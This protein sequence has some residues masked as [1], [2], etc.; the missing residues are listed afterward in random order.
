MDL[1]QAKII[2]NKINA[3]YKNLSIDEGNIA[4]IEKELMLNYIRQLYE[5]FLDLDQPTSKKKSKKSKAPV[6]EPEF[7]VVKPKAKAPKKEYVPPKIIEIPDSLKEISEE[8]TP[9]PQPKP[10]PK[11][12]PLN[13]DAR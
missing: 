7:E 3:L 8:P 12:W 4:S 11:P 5:A 9:A 2:L 1:Q 13:P 10:K 6:E